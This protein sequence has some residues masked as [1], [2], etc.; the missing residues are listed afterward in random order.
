MHRTVL[1]PN[2]FVNKCI[3]SHRFVDFRLMLNPDLKGNKDRVARARRPKK[4]DVDGEIGPKCISTVR[5][6]EKRPI[7]SRTNARYSGGNN[8]V[9]HATERRVQCAAFLYDAAI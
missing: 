8:E 7:A 2:R 6:T 3:L 1:C 5:P 4:I 9:T